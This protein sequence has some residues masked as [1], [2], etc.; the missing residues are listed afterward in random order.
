MLS[1]PPYQP[2]GRKVAAREESARFGLGGEDSRPCHASPVLQFARLN[3][4][5][6][7][8]LLAHVP[9]QSLLAPPSGP[10]A[11][12]PRRGAFYDA[13]VAALGGRRGAE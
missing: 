5:T 6:H 2:L 3:R 9:G 7:P 1:A 13:S 12:A 4:T 10:R 11:H 8:A